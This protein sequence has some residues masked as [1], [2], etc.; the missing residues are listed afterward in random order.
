MVFL[1]YKK[2]LAIYPGNPKDLTPESLLNN[3]KTLLS[4][5]I[6]ASITFMVGAK[7]EAG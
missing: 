2:R 3:E 6:L 7:F 5:L 4:V 1:L